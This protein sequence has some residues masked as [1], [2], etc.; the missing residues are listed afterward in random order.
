MKAQ[1]QDRIEAVK[2]TVADNVSHARETLTGKKDELAARAKQVTPD[3]TTAGA[4]QVGT[5]MQ[6]H[7][8]PYAA[9]GTFAGGLLLGW[10]LARR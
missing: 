1:A 3:S 5:A 8:L 4:Q 6:R 10:L 2:H 7:P 9:V